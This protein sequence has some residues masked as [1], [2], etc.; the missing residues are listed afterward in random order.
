MCE[1]SL[2]VI[3]WRVGSVANIWILLKNLEP[4]G[5]GRGGSATGYGIRNRARPAEALKQKGTYVLSASLIHGHLLTS[6]AILETYVYA[7]HPDLSFTLSRNPGAGLR[8][9][10]AARQRLPD[11]KRNIGSCA[12]SMP[13]EALL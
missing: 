11:A 12:R 6:C 13:Y 2:G 1:A 3:R 4:S 10:G 9:Y 5:L 7:A 8:R